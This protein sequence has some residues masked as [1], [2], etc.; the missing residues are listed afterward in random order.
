MVH[1]MA[2]D[3]RPDPDIVQRETTSGRWIQSVLPV[4]EFLLAG[5]SIV[6]LTGTA[7]LLQPFTGYQT[8]A[9]LYLLLVVALG[10][11]LSR[12]PVLAVAATSAILWNFLFVPPS[13][14]FYIHNFH[15]GIMFI[16]FFVVAVAMGH[17]TNQLRRSESAE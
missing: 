12:G 16:A 17:L 11:K 1:C 2:K 5:I 7:W 15:D 14:T 10:L 6:A 3:P 13:F 9:L 4:H 8:V